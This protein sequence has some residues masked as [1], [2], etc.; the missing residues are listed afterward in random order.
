MFIDEVYSL[1][2]SENRDSFAKECIDTINLNM[3]RKE[4]WLLIVGGYKEDIYKSFMS[5]NK[6]L[7]RRFTVRLEINNY[8]ADELYKILNKFINDDNFNIESDAIKISDIEQNINLFKFYAGDMLKLYQ[9]AKEFYSLR[10][11]KE[12]ITLNNN[13]RILK[14]EDFENSIN[15]FK[16]SKSEDKDSLYKL[17]MY[18]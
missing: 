13:L 10:L 12:S 3:T 6:G 4:P 17:S 7:E 15:Y 16:L 5:Y 18:S 1:G 14:K 8:T 2:N 11:M 9:K